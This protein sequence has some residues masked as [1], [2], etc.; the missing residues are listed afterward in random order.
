MPWLLQ[1]T[2]SSAAA[3]AAG[4]HALKLRCS[5]SGSSR[6]PCDSLA[7]LTP[8]R[9]FHGAQHR[10]RIEGSETNQVFLRN[11]LL[12][13][14]C[15]IIQAR[16]CGTAAITSHGQSV[17]LS[18]CQSDNNHVLLHLKSCISLALRTSFLFVTNS[19]FRTSLFVDVGRIHSEL[20]AP[21]LPGFRHTRHSAALHLRRCQ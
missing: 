12:T 11:L 7:S 21:R 20:C 10:A 9:P 19:S 18:V 4:E 8:S 5:R 16:L 15:P 1:S 13:T 3:A 17:S 14:P 6:I 2:P